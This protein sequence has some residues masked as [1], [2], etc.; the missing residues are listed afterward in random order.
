MTLGNFSM[1]LSPTALCAVVIDTKNTQTFQWIF[2]Q[3]GI[4]YEE[5]YINYFSIPVLVPNCPSLPLNKK[6]KKD[7]RFLSLKM[8]KSTIRNVFGLRSIQYI[9]Y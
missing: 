9:N 8:A 2:Y 7:V 3:P 6:F 1:Y 5:G 4:I